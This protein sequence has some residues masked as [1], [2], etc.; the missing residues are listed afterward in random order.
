MSIQIQDRDN[1]LAVREVWRVPSDVQFGDDVQLLI[2]V[3]SGKF[4]GEATAFFDQ[5]RLLEFN[6]VLRELER[7]RT[8]FAELTTLYS[9][10]VRLRFEIADGWGRTRVVGKI[11]NYDHGGSQPCKHSLEFGFDFD[12]TLL[13]SIVSG[14]AAFCAN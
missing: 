1:R 14:F 13:P 11:I 10:E 6:S 9:D 2:E 5:P 12:P 4:V 8:G 7:S 3:V